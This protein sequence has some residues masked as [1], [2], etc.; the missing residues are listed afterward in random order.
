MTEPFATP[1]AALM[2][3]H[4][5]DGRCE[6]LG[7]RTERRGEVRAVERVEITENGL[8]G[9]HRSRP[10]KRAVT[11][12]QSEHLPV[13]AALVADGAEV[14]WE[15]LRRNIV[16]SG[17]NLLALRDAEFRIGGA[18]L[19]GTGICAPCSRMTEAFGPG[20]YNAVRGHGG[21]TAAVVEPGPVAIGDRLSVPR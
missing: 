2:G 17:I 21:I 8:F 10:G 19:R 12:I 9:D 6:W 1:L 20:G 16:V 11:L 3:T 18:L 15:A 7:V 5:R 13:I 4:A 14:S